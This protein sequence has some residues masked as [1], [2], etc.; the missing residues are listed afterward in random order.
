MENCPICNAKL[1][2]IKIYVIKGDELEVI[3]ENF[4]CPKFSCR[5]EIDE[6]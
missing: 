4:Y 5:F 3:G 1:E 2:K 6:Q